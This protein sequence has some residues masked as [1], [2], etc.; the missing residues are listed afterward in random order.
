VVIILGLMAALAVNE[1]W[2]IETVQQPEHVS[3][4]VGGM[5]SLEDGTLLVCTRRGEVWAIENPHAA[6]PKYVLYADGLHEPLGLLPYDG[7]IY[8]AQRGEL[9][10]MRDVDGDHRIDELETICDDWEISGNYHEYAFGPRVDP[11][12][13]FW[14]TL[15]KPFGDEPFGKAHWR[16]W[17][18]RI[19]PDGQ[20]SGACSGLRSPAGVETSPWG[21]VF[22]TDNQGEWCGASKLSHLEVGD[23]HGHPHG[24][25]S[26]TLDASLVKHPGTVPD[27]LLMPEV[28]EH[29][30]HFKLPA[31]WFPYDR[32]GRS[33]SGFVWDTTAGGF[34]PFAGQA[35]VGDQ[36]API[37]M[38]VD[39]EEIDGH[40]QGACYPFLDGFAC[41]ITRLAWS[42]S[43]GSPVLLVGMTDRGWP[44]LGSRSDGVQRATFTGEVPFAVKT[45]RVRSDGFR[46]T[47][48]EAVDPPTA[49]ADSFVMR[50]FTYKLH[51]PYGSPEVDEAEPEIV[52]A[53]VSE[54]GLVIDLVITG[55]REGYVHDLEFP[56]LRNAAGQKLSHERACYTL[57]NR[58]G[59]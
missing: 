50:S 10:R 48:T 40:W 3:L 2:V 25:D 24:I 39:L 28:S 12:G 32:M 11:E 37:V 19:S 52:S 49:I 17:A 47:L 29:I 55:L 9:S 13:N 27:G 56:G 4:E 42:E 59:A 5:A 35:Y 22:Y 38:R 57:I 41:G 45:M 18:A 23:F 54:D 21:D 31:V 20:M 6:E 58:P 36:Y 7:W 33:P 26:S 46:L 51:S 43:E 15:N 16:G 14:V 1:G 30:P 53:S 8:T 34:G 44:S